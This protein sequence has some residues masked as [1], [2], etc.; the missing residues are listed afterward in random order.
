MPMSNENSPLPHGPAEAASVLAEDA[1]FG[2][3]TLR[4]HGWRIALLF[5]LV[6]LPLWGF[7]QLAD[8]VHEGEILPFDRPL[9]D[10]AHALASHGLDALALLLA[11]L[12]YG[13]GVV[14]FDLALVLALAVRRRKPEGLFAGIALAGSALLNIG[15]KHY[16]GRARPAYWLSLAPETSYSFPSGHAMASMTLAMVLAL[17]AWRTRWRWP[18]ACLA[19]AFALLVG[20]SRVYLGVHFPSDIL[21]GWTAAVAWTFGAYAVVFRGTLRPWRH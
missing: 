11:K 17:L 9:L 5:A 13:Y 3:G 15:A 10:A 6:L 7:G 12:G 16:F 1:R 21:A 19:F 2:I 14:P 18:V 4:R 20:A 8:E